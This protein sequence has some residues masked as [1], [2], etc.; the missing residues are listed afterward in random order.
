MEIEIEWLKLMET[1]LFQVAND[2][3]DIVGIEIRLK[4]NSFNG[5]D[6]GCNP[7]KESDD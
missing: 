2:C 1:N 6:C 7:M 3:N 5:Q 4:L